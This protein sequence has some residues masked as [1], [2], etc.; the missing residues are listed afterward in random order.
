MY[1]QTTTRDLINAN[2]VTGEPK[3]G[4]RRFWTNREVEIVEAHYPKFGLQGLT[5]KLPGRT[6]YAI[7]TKAKALKLSA[8]PD[9]YARSDRPR[10]KRRLASPEIDLYLREHVP[11]AGTKTSME[12]IAKAINRPR[13]WVSARASQ[14]GLVHTRFKE[15]AWTKAEEEFAAER[16][17]WKFDALQRAM[18]A[19]GW[20]RTTTSIGCKLKRLGASRI[21]PDH[22]SARGLGM[23]LGVN[24]RTIS[25]WIE[26]GLLGATRRGTNRVAQQGGDEW[27]ISRRQVFDFV[28]S[29]AHV[30]DLRKVEKYWFIDILAAGPNGA[31][32]LKRTH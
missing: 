30:V 5:S 17:H 21:D 9:L 20:N 23:L 1:D 31:R 13:W 3:R 15:P 6:A 8:P 32:T 12:A 2:E 27:S 29:N 19:R 11:N 28:V 7:Y 16:A 14:L 22:Y 18:K 4:P 26:K 10:A 24:G 25:A